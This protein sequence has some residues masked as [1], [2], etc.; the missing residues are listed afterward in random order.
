MDYVDTLPWD[1]LLLSPD[2]VRKCTE[3]LKITPIELLNVAISKCHP[4][5]WQALFWMREWFDQI[6]RN[7]V[8]D[9]AEARKEFEDLHATKQIE[10]NRAKAKAMADARHNKPGGAREK[11]A[12]IRAIW[13]SGKYSSRTVCAEQECGA[14][15]MSYDTARRALRNT[16]HPVKG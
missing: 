15:G 10:E 4:S 16:P 14:L 3:R 6:H 8:E 9:I 11:R 2:V 1:D 12:A 7:A 5:N 13:A